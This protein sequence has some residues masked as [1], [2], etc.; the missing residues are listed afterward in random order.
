M[1]GKK[2]LSTIRQEL[3]AALAATGMDPIAW[4]E[5]SITAAKRRGES[6]QVMESLKRVL[7]GPKTNR[8]G[9]QASRRTRT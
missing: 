9:Q 5:E 6:S 3:H 8:R 2:K 4:L 1:M 7:Q